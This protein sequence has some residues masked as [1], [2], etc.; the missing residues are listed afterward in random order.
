MGLRMR[1]VDH[2]DAGVLRL[3]RQ[4]GHDRGEHAH[5]APRLPAIVERLRR[6][7]GG[8]RVLPQGPQTTKLMIAIDTPDSAAEQPDGL[9]GADSARLLTRMAGT[10]G[11]RLEDC[12]LAPLS[13][14]AP[15][16]GMVPAP[17]LGQLVDRMRH[18][19]SLVNPAA[20][21]LLGDQANRA[22]I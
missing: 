16:A 11:L 19:I 1:R 8:R 14:I 12:Y 10:I 15:P 5:P 13:L 6:A 22:L 17:V 20:L 18:H 21:L 9:F 3:C 7:I 4:F 2:H